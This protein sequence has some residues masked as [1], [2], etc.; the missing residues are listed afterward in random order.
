M[1]G[2]PTISTSRFGFESAV[3]PDGVPLPSP[4]RRRGS[5]TDATGSHDG[6]LST[7][8]AAVPANSALS[9]GGPNSGT[10]YEYADF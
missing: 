8:N 5:G 6:D 10:D 7:T 1:R 9:S 4:P 3:L 2:W